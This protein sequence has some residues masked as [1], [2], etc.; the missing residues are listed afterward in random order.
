MT[1]CSL[2]SRYAIRALDWIFER[3]IFR[4]SHF[5]ADAGIPARTARR[6]VDA[7]CDGGILRVIGRGRG[8]RTTVLA[9]FALIETVEGGKGLIG[10]P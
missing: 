4:S 6:I 5:V 9:F 8:R 1:G 7:L 3:P 10:H 2:R